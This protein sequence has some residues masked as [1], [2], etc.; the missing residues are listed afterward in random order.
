MKYFKYNFIE[1]ELDGLQSLELSEDGKTA[2]IG[3]GNDEG[4]LIEFDVHNKKVVKKYWT[5]GSHTS[6]IL[7]ISNTKAIAGTN[8]GFFLVVDLINKDIVFK[9]QISNTFIRN[10]K[11]SNDKSTIYLITNSEIIS[12]CG[13]SFNLL[14]KR[15]LS[16][17]PWDI[18]TID[19]SD[20]LVIGGSKNRL[21]LVDP[22]L[23][24]IDS[25]T[26]G[27]EYRAIGF[28]SFNKF[29]NL[30]F[31]G[32]ESKE[33]ISWEILEEKLKSVYHIEYDRDITY[34][35]SLEQYVIFSTLDGHILIDLKAKMQFKIK[36]SMGESRF[37]LKNIGDKTYLFYQEKNR[38]LSVIDVKEPEKITFKLSDLP[39]GIR[40]IE[41]SS[42]G[43]L[44]A[45]N[46]DGIFISNFIK[47]IKLENE[48]QFDYNSKKQNIAISEFIVDDESEKIIFQSKDKSIKILS[49]IDNSITDVNVALD[50]YDEC[51]IRDY[52]KDKLLLT[53]YEYIYIIDT[54]SNNTIKLSK[55]NNNFLPILDIK[56]VDKNRFAIINNSDYIPTPIIKDYLKVYDFEGNTIS[57]KELNDAYGA[58]F[59]SHNKLITTYISSSESSKIIDI[60]TNNTKEFDIGYCFG[61]D[62][63][64]IVFDNE[65][66][67]IRI[68]IGERIGDDYCMDC[69]DLTTVDKKGRNNRIWTVEDPRLSS[70]MPLGYCKLNDLFYIVDKKSGNLISIDKNSGDIIK[71]YK[72][73][74]NI[75]HITISNNGKYIAWTLFTGEFS[76]IKYPF[77]SCEVTDVNKKWRNQRQLKND[78]R[79]TAELW[80]DVFT[81]VTNNN[82]FYSFGSNMHQ[83][84]PFN[85]SLNIPDKSCLKYFNKDMAMLSLLGKV[86]DDNDKKYEE[87]ATIYHELFHVFQSISMKKVFN[88]FYLIDELQKTRSELLEY[89][90]YADYYTLNELTNNNFG[91]T[92]FHSVENYEKI[93]NIETNSS[94]FN[95]IIAERYKEIDSDIEKLIIENI[96]DEKEIITEAENAKKNFKRKIEKMFIEINKQAKEI[97]DYA[98]LSKI[99]LRELR[100]LISYFKFYKDLNLNIFHLIEGSAQ[101]F[102]WCCA[103]YNIDSKLASHKE[104]L[105]KNGIDDNTYERAYDLFQENGGKT[106]LLFIMISI[107]S[108]FSNKPID[109]F[110]YC[111]GKVSLWEDDFLNSDN[112]EQND[113]DSIIEHIK[114]SISGEFYNFDTKSIH[115]TYK[116]NIFLQSINSIRK[117]ISESKNIS[118]FINLLLNEEIVL[119]LIDIFDK[120]KKEFKN[121]L[122][123]NEVMRDFEKFLRFDGTD[124]ELKC[125]EEHGSGIVFDMPWDS[126]KNSDSF[127]NILK[128]EFKVKIPNLL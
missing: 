19:N 71:T 9:Q 84:D 82:N 100:E 25:Q 2:L 121:E 32:G 108:L 30:L 75:K 111:L 64:T 51:E 118:F 8:N 98:D 41:M 97:K 85:Y 72:L 21:E 50:F 1:E 48:N 70:Y 117:E 120:H 124:F 13:K 3:F 17:T 91:K 81:R 11:L 58:I 40:F 45:I 89:L 61:R 43:D 35:T 119:K 54:I 86:N 103:G 69:Y 127:N 63:D 112:I 49:L 55:D 73:Q 28:L 74:E 67:C 77:V 79:S 14:N 107:L 110:I 102:G 94:F 5:E 92:I 78:I 116:N 16:F 68:T 65:R 22:T 80:W 23:K 66:Y 99:E 33:L 114:N 7:F 18:S 44:I 27:D 57:S 126:C 96:A 59:N 101:I 87:V 62:S 52:Y 122:R 104:Y 128:N 125:C 34:L 105:K 83:L 20:L 15:V 109:V 123:K 4:Q 47:D 115:D 113:I 39:S 6:A 46:S 56:L 38:T 31:S 10:I 26:C 36:N 60:N 93:T 24:I 76:C 42:S 37:S 106:P 90:G 12:L 53:T 95:K 88:Y 29:A